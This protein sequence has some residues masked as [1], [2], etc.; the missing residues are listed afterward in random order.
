M[1]CA[2]HEQR[3]GSAPWSC[4]LWSG[5]PTRRILIPRSCPA[6]SSNARPSRALAMDPKAMLFDEVTSA[7]D[8]ELVAEVLAV[9][10]RLAGQGMTMLVVTHE[11]SF[12]RQ[13]ASRVVFMDHGRIV[14]EASPE[15]IFGA[16][17]TAHARFPAHGAGAVGRIRSGQIADRKADLD[18]NHRPN[19][20]IATSQRQ[21][22]RRPE[23][24]L[25][26]GASM[27]SAWPGS[28]GECRE[29]PAYELLLLL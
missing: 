5:S 17:R 9:M 4:S 20:W 18:L 25:P 7:L 14:E 6:V 13:V 2:N 26:G 8:P 1:C 19:G 24:R 16:P 11:M 15:Q 10:R 23:S 12:A 22:S 3:P 28:E 27:V 29:R 21:E